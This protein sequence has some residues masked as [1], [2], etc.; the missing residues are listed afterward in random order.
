[1]GHAKRRG[2]RASSARAAAS[3]WASLG[4]PMFQSSIPASRSADP[5]RTRRAA[6]LWRTGIPQAR[7]ACETRAGSRV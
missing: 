6:S 1:M 4:L 7:S 5:R 2:A 3:V